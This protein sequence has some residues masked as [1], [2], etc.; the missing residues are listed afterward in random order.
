MSYHRYAY[1]APSQDQQWNEQQQLLKSSNWC[2]FN[3]ESIYRNHQRLLLDSD[4]RAAFDAI[5][6]RLFSDTMRFKEASEIFDLLGGSPPSR[7]S[8]K[9]KKK[10]KATSSSKR[11][12]KRQKQEAP[13]ERPQKGDVSER[14]DAEMSDAGASS[15]SDSDSGNSSDD[16]DEH[17]R[18]SSKSG[19]RLH[20]YVI[21]KDFVEN[22]F[23]RFCNQE[24]RIFLLDAL[25]WIWIAG[26][27]P[28]MFVN[29][30]QYG[31]L[32]RCLRPDLIDIQFRCTAASQFD[33]R[34]RSTIIGVSKRDELRCNA[35]QTVD[36]F[37]G[38]SSVGTGRPALSV[39]SPSAP[40]DGV[41]REHIVTDG[42][43]VGAQDINGVYTFIFNK[44]TALGTPT[45]LL[46]TLDADL[47]L[48]DKLRTFKLQQ[49]QE[50]TRP[51]VLIATAIQK[52][53]L[54]LAQQA[55]E[56]FGANALANS[57][58]LIMN[59]KFGPQLAPADAS[60][61]GRD[62]N[63][64]MAA[65]LERKMAA[66]GEMYNRLA[67]AMA[68]GA[69]SLGGGG[70]SSSSAGGRAA[71]DIWPEET[72]IPGMGG[73]S[74]SAES[75]RLHSLGPDEKPSVVSRQDVGYTLEELGHLRMRVIGKVTRVPDVLLGSATES[76]RTRANNVEAQ[77]PPAQM[78]SATC[79]QAGKYLAW[80]A[81]E[82]FARIYADE[83]ARTVAESTETVEGAR[84][85]MY[86]KRVNL[87]FD[88]NVEPA[89]VEK[90]L[91]VGGL[92]WSKYV[93]YMARRYGIPPD[94]LL[95]KPVV[96]PVTSLGFDMG[97]MQAHMQLELAAAQ[98]EAAAESQ[99][100]HAPPT[101]S[102][103]GGG[104]SSGKSKNGTPSMNSGTT[105][106]LSTDKRSQLFNSKFSAN[107]M[108][109]TTKL[110]YG[111]DAQDRRSA[112]TKKSAKR[113]GRKSGEKRKR[114]NTIDRG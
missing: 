84:L 89:M 107:L 69:G 35:D 85:A 111:D 38:A 24:W 81:E 99:A 55:G 87:I 78:F 82:C 48:L 102:G 18:K 114:Q 11:P 110:D 88:G 4:I 7:K 104:S 10:K 31:S 96:P 79:L 47:R 16:D 83:L 72:A 108:G 70:A 57:S 60:N 56:A 109:P 3:M 59:P 46:Q 36:T 66:M 94:D 26:F 75:L 5:A 30:D 51:Q 93:K 40:E 34:Y 77:S 32:P 13:V 25:E 27:V 17:E 62:Q 9:P 101:A 86:T 37:K 33:F 65:E 63:A 54:A 22:G 113:G 49:A 1:S 44:P 64:V 91:D 106:P 6:S 53:A 28:V 2:S 67:N 80:I 58:R 45:S 50:I 100:R 98:A 97:L 19:A 95:P 112:R 61:V 92:S 21:P 105:K 29:H 76:G 15:D 103:S 68:K 41:Y 20:T 14:S 74:S 71:D 8:K 12:H 90:L 42:P 23:E 73:A 43:I 39:Q 52:E